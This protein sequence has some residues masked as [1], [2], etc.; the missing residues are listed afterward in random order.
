MTFQRLDLS[1][2]RNIY[3][4]GDIHGH[5]TVLEEKLAS[6]DFDP[7]V[8]HLIS[9]GDLVDRGPE[10]ERCLEFCDQPWFHWVRGNHE[11]LTL[12][13]A[14]GRGLKLKNGQLWL[15]DTLP[16]KVA[17]ISNTINAAPNILEVLAP[18]GKRYGFVHATFPSSDWDDAARV[19]RDI[20]MLL[21]DREDYFNPKL[22]GIANIDHVYHGHT[23]LWNEIK[24]VANVSW[25]DTGVYRSQ[26]C[27]T[28]V[29]LP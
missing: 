6:V 28:I 7:K 1:H 21:W 12:D 10:N 22:D 15:L 3:A 27:L 29:K 13:Y 19:S 5:Y 16:S 8:D 25:I 18:S 23:P 20:D 4:V 14:E 26:G 2:A 17:I 11:E 9:V 24:T